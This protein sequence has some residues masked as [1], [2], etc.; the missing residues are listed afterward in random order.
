MRTALAV[1]AIA[2]FVPAVGS[3]ARQDAVAP[4]GSSVSTGLATAI[5]TLGTD[6]CTNPNARV[7]PD[8]FPTRVGAVTSSDG[9]TWTVPGVAEW[10][11]PAVDLYN[12]CTGTGDNPGWAQQLKTVVIDPDGVEITGFIFADN[13]YELYVNGRFVARDGVAMTPFN[14]T[15]VRFR[16]RYPITYAVKA[17][18]WET[19]HGVGMEY[20][21][22]N[23]GDGG[24]IAYFS[25]G[26]RT[27]AGWHA[28]T[29]YIAPL[30]DPLCVRTTGG[31]DSSFCSQAVRPACAQKDPA[32]CRALHFPVPAGWA[33][34]RFDASA[35]PHAVVWR[36][37]EVTGVPAYVNYTSRFGDARFIWTRGIRLDNL[38]LARHTANG[39]RTPE[40]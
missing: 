12:D 36:P 32:T 21:A 14:S 5:T 29:F 10:G 8:V 22:F 11:A 2:A 6:G 31:R 15:V 16:A 7:Q 20:Q 34:P 37:V 39:P 4:A 19:R 25:D 33:S 40:R 9:R 1:A 17:I 38:V 13:Y 30:D 35:W 26:T 28:E 18:D 3:P 23:I 24:F 27:D